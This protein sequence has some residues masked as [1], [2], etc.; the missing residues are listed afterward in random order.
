MTKLLGLVAGLLVG[1]FLFHQ[2]GFDHHR[3]YG[4]Q[5]YQGAVLLAAIGLAGVFPEAWLSAAIALGIAPSLVFCYEIVYLHPAESMWPVVLPLL[6]LLSFPAPLIGS[7]M[8]KLLMCIRLP[9][10]VYVVPLTGALIIG[11][12]LPNLQNLWLRRVETVTVP[13]LLKQIYEAEMTYS[14]RQPEG[15][16]ICDG[17]VRRASWVG[18]TGTVQSI[19]ISSSTSTPLVL[20]APMRSTLAASGSPPTRMKAI[21]LPRTCL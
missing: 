4:W 15:N 3:F 18:T 14:A 1:G 9:Q 6:V 5:W 11:T 8:T 10:A 13:R 21:S 17:T 12:F 7:C 2:F 20:I 16:F 19:S